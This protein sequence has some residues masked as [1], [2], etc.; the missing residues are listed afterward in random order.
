MRI[1]VIFLLLASSVASAG[2]PEPSELQDAV[3]VVMGSNFGDDDEEPLLFSEADARRFAQVLVEL[4]GLA[5]NRALVLVPRSREQ[6][7]K[8]LAEAR[9]RIAE[10][11]STG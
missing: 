5:A 4:G 7:L 6:V 8:A 10:I 1:T 11:Q 3:A 9:G 2:P